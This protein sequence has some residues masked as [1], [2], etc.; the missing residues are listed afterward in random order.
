MI[1]SDVLN[2]LSTG[3]Y[4]RN[5]LWTSFSTNLIAYAVVVFLGWIVTWRIVDYFLWR[6]EGRVQRDLAQRCFGHLIG[7]SADFH[8]NTFGG[9][10]VSQ[11]TKLMGSY[12]RIADATVLQL[13]P[14]VCALGS[15]M[16]TKAAL[17]AVI[18][19]CSQWSTSSSRRSSRTRCGAS[20]RSMPPPRAR[21]PA[22][23]PTPSP[24]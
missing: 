17:F 14:L 7:Q 2:R 13:L 11:T 19:P 12:I 3:H 4:Q 18:S 10:L 23:W 6:L 20:A 1:V 5:Q 24:M 15:I 21:R 9:A 22:T 16:A 8:A